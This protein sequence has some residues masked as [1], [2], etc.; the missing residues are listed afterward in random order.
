[1]QTHDYDWKNCTG[2][3]DPHT[4][5]EPDPYEP[6]AQTYVR[7]REDTEDEWMLDTLAEIIW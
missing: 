6:W 4:P 2:Y 3:Y 7:W 1:M 5:H